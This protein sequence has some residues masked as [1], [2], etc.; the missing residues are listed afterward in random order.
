MSFELKFENIISLKV[1]NIL[2]IELNVES[3][4]FN[5]IKNLKSSKIIKKN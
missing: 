1:G 2:K 3:A 5:L 4:K